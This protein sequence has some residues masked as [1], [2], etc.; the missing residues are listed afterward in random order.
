MALEAHTDESLARIATLAEAV[1]KQ[2]GADAV[3]VAEYQ[4][5]NASGEVA[6]SWYAIMGYLQARAPGFDAT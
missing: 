3:R 6:E 5:K 4:A 1:V 2:F